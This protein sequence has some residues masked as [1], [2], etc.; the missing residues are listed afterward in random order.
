MTLSKRFQLHVFQSI[1]S[2]FLILD[3]FHYFIFQFTYSF[4]YHLILLLYSL[5]DFF[6]FQITFIF[7][8][9]DFLFSFIMN[10][11][12]YTVFRRVTKPA[13]KPLLSSL[14]NIWFILGL[15]LL[16]SVFPFL[17][18]Y[19]ILFWFWFVVV[20]AVLAYILDIMNSKW[21]RFWILLLFFCEGSFIF[22]WKLCWVYL[23]CSHYCKE[24]QLLLSHFRSFV[25]SWTSLHLF[26]KFLI[27]ALG[28]D[29]DEQ[30]PL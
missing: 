10:R 23:N 17:R 29:V 13:S 15:N 8:G 5:G 16:C 22:F 12:C 7:I 30:N 9:W 21:L 3:N 20:C 26:H 11:F 1:F 14:F 6:Q 25:F 18:I 4:L 28:R 24:R 27:K 2:L 19:F